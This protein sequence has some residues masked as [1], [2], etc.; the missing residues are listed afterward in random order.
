MWVEFYSYC[1]EYVHIGEVYKKEMNH[2]N[3]LKDFSREMKTSVLR[4]KSSLVLLR[5]DDE[6]SE[7]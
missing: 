6:R 7:N 1:V 5:N 2:F 3:H 4:H